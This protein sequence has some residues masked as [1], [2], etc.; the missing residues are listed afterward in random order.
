MKKEH[1]AKIR[2]KKKK[3]N[4]RPEQGQSIHEKEGTEGIISRKAISLPRDSF[5]NNVQMG[6]PAPTKDEVE[7]KRKL[8]G[9]QETKN[10]I[11]SGTSSVTQK[12]G[13]G[14]CFGK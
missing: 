8:C 13:K 9:Y 3:G 6:S 12:L 14:P 5:T 4:R 7:E 1:A 2:E 11:R 10:E